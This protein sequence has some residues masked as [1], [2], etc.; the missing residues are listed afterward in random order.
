MRK[1]FKLVGSFDTETTADPEHPQFAF[2]CLLQL[3]TW[4]KLSGKGTT[5]FYSTPEELVD[6]LPMDPEVTPIIA[7]YNLS[8]DFVSLAPVL[9]E[10]GFTFEAF[11]PE[12]SP[13]YIDVLEGKNA[14]LRF[15]EVST[16]VPQ[17]LE[18]MGELAGVPKLK[19]E[20]D[21]S[22]YR[23]PGTELTEEEKAYATRDTEVIQA[24]LQHLLQTSPFLKE[25]DLGTR[26]LTQTGL[27]R[28]YGERV[29]GRKEVRRFVSSADREEPKTEASYRLRKACFRAGLAFT[30]GKNAGR[31]FENV[32]SI[33]TVSMH[34]SFILGRQVPIDFHE[35]SPKMI[36]LAVKS[37]LS[38]SLE[39]V[40][41]NYDQP[42]KVA[43][44]AKIRFT[45][46]RL[47]KGSVFKQQGIAT[48]ARSKFAEQVAY[49]MDDSKSSETAENRNRF[50]GYHDSGNGLVLAFGKIVKAEEAELFL[51]ETETWLIGKV[52]DWD[53]FEVLEGEIA[54]RFQEPPTFILKLDESLYKAKKGMKAVL[55]GGDSKLIPTAIKKAPRAVQE[56]YYKLSSKAQFNSIFGLCAMDSH[57]FE[58]TFKPDR[59][60]K[61]WYTLGMRIAGG[62]RLHLAL[63]LILLDREYRGRFEVLGGDTDSIK[64][65]G[66]T[67]AEIQSALRPLHDAITRAIQKTLTAAGIEPSQFAGIGTFESEGVSEWEVEIFNK[68]RLAWTGDRFKLTAAGIPTPADHTNLEDALTALAHKWG[69]IVVMNLV[70]G[71]NLNV[72]SSL[73]CF[74]LPV[75]PQDRLCKEF[76]A[77]TALVPIAR[78]IGDLFSVE[79]AS[80]RKNLPRSYNPSEISLEGD[81]V[82]VRDAFTQVELYTAEIT[83]RNNSNRR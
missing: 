62:S 4:S 17:G 67:D 71:P 36:E 68:N 54:V 82:I 60:P 75:K 27:V 46:L 80:V 21:Y 65:A 31:I 1:K 28:L 10:R 2:V 40:L 11:G 5:R 76:A 64:L 3:R 50:L 8:F 49:N 22:K 53:S 52:Y 74:L 25:S 38:T 12:S 7:V 32:A 48:L 9:E 59:S 39:S 63:A 43:F 33:D 45:N 55:H 34:H 47:K 18:V 73:S 24:Y 19:G 81:L 57:K 37:V 30:A 6:S 26:L 61:S 35:A 79:M 58:T 44:H 51:T 20:W 83:S 66:L 69:P 14:V 72:D 15:W 42:F 77:A 13:F 29:V 78:T 56:A 41:E 23:E 16:L 70:Y